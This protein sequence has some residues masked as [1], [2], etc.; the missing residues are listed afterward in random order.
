MIK[1]TIVTL[2]VIFFPVFALPNTVFAAAPSVESMSNSGTNVGRYEKFELTFQISRKFDANSFLPYY[3]YDAADTPSRFPGRTSPYGVDGITIEAHFI[4]PSGQEKT[5]PAFYFQDYNR[6]GD[7]MTPTNNYS[8]KVRF[9]PEQL[10]QYRYYLTLQDKDGTTRHPSTGYLTMNV[11]KSDSKGFVRQSSR[12]PRFLEFSNGQSFIPNSSGLQWWRNGKRT[13]YYE[14]AFQN[15]KN[16]NVN[17]F[18]LWDQNDS[19]GLTV[20]GHF[21]AY[22]FPDDFKPTDTGVDIASLPKGTQMNQRGNYEEDIIINSAEQNGVYMVVSSHGDPYWI[23]DASVYNEN[24][25]QNPVTFDNQQH[26]DYWKRNFRYRVARWGYSPA[27]VAWELWNEHGN[28]SSTSSAYRFY[29]T[30]GAYQL[31]TDPYRHLRT[32]SQGSQAWSPALW[33]SNAFDYASYHDYMMISRY[34]ADLTYDAGNFV[35]R[36][37]QCIRKDNTSGCGL[38]LSDTSQWDGGAKPIFWGELDTGTTQWN[39]ANP[40]QRATH[41][42]RWAGLFSPIGMSP[43]DWYYDVQTASF[44]S[45][46]LADAR[47]AGEFFKDI[48]YAGAR[49]AYESTSDVRISSSQISTSNNKIRVLGMKSQDKKQAYVWAQNKDN[50]RWDT[51]IV[52]PS[53]SGNFTLTGMMTGKYNIEYWDTKTGSVTKSSASSNGGN[54]VIPVSNISRDIAIKIRHETYSSGETL[55]TTYPGDANGDLRVD[56]VDYVIWLNNYNT[57]QQGSS[58][59]DFDNNG[60]V[61]GVDYVI[62]LNNYV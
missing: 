56:G 30:Y 27:V 2:F 32:T 9:A 18:R 46:K 50:A 58:K 29:Q 22:E 36:F 8:W 10:G 1:N 44:L 47:I 24:W 34:S 15:F 4:A 26:I 54:L 14:E 37:A 23:W 41:D 40:A 11:N 20:E 45:E 42:M 16:S 55:P 13:T 61:D 51:S 48:D 31:Q 3:Y 62:W 60:R 28:V 35:Y 7:K 59:G 57:N 17:F 49:F 12:D 38:G 39:Q 25:N 52:N 6:A 53:I 5:V 43:I 21:D 19:Y 33:G